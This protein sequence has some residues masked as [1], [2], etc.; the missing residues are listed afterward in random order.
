MNA[1]GWAEIALTLAVTVALAWAGLVSLP[2]VRGQ[3]P[4]W[5]ASSRPD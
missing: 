5:F 3:P 2:V 4:R 1:Q